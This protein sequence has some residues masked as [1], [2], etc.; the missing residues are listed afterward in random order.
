MIEEALDLKILVACKRCGKALSVTLKEFNFA[1]SLISIEASPCSCVNYE[2]ELEG[3][4]DIAS[5]LSDDL[6]RVKDEL[7]E[8]QEENSNL[9]ADRQNAERCIAQLEAQL[10]TSRHDYKLL[11]KASQ[12]A[13]NEIM[14]LES[15]KGVKE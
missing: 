5:N 12:D 1:Q 14:R 6:D 9:V 8:A 3:L 11:E 15:E 10:E 2:D 13:L 4:R 7:K